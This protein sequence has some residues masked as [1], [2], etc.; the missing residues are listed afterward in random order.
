MAKIWPVYNGNDPTRGGPWAELPLTK[1]INLFGL[2]PDNFLSGLDETPRPRFGNQYES[3]FYK[4]YKHIVV[5]V[6]QSEARKTKWRP[7]FYKAEVTPSEAFDLLVKDALA[8]TLGWDNVLRVLRESAADSRGHDAL[9]F[10]VVIA[11]NAIPALAEKSLDALV[12]LQSRLSEMREERTPIIE[13]STE[14][15]LAQNANS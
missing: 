10:T 5:E 7:G 13:F 6:G 8:S 12:N 11:P 1:A 9:K 3:H 2:R 15:E 4:G 14:E